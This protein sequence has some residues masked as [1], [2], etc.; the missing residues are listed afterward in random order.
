MT[1]ALFFFALL[2]LYTGLSLATVI[3]DPQIQ[4]ISL[5][6][7]ARVYATTPDLPVE[8]ILRDTSIPGSPLTPT[9][10]PMVLPNRLTGLTLP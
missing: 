3:V 4:S 7:Q 10:P 6:S 9:Y 2:I 5:G 1:R 8:H